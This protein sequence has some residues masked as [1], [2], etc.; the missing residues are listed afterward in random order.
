MG[1]DSHET[2]RPNGSGDLRDVKI[3]WGKFEEDTLSSGKLGWG[4]LQGHTQS[5]ETSRLPRRD[6]PWTFESMVW[7]LRK[8]LWIEDAR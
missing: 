6:V 5:F 4:T 3:R 8:E 7:E 2:G 1:V